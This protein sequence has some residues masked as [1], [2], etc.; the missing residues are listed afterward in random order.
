[1]PVTAEE[2]HDDGI[3]QNHVSSLLVQAE[4]AAVDSFAAAAEG[5]F[6]ELAMGFGTPQ[7]SGAHG[8]R[9]TGSG[10]PNTMSGRRGLGVMGLPHSPSTMCEASPLHHAH[11]PSALTHSHRT[12][13]ALTHSAGTVR[14]RIY[15]SS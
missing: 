7:S 9:G 3:I 14:A 1:M 11:T 15:H 10:G 12:D 2:E 6:E 8:L 5:E 4:M 13:E